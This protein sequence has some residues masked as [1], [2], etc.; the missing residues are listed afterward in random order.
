MDLKK[1]WQKK[2]GW[3][4]S[5]PYCDQWWALVN[6]VMNHMVP[7]SRKYLNQMDYWLL[8]SDSA[9]WNKLVTAT[10]TRLMDH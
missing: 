1:I 6:I 2:V 10:V 7:S 9:P 3:I 8:E 4:L 5:A